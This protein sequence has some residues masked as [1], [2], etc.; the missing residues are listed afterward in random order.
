[1]TT[2]QLSAYL[3]VFQAK[4]ALQASLEI[5]WQIEGTTTISTV[6]LTVMFAPQALP[7]HDTAVVQ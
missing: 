2:Q 5:P 1:M 3:E 7:V 6:K 4:N